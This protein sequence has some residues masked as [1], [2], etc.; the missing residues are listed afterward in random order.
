M[1]LT[2]ELDN[3]SL[4]SKSLILEVHTEDSGNLH[5]MYRN[6]NV[7]KKEFRRPLYFFVSRTCFLVFV[8][9]PLR[10]EKMCGYGFFPYARSGRRKGGCN[11]LCKP[12]RITQQLVA[13]IIHKE[14]RH[15]VEIY[16]R[17]LFPALHV[18]KSSQTADYGF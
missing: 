4:S 13:R 10:L 8:S 18:R 3:R 16:P 1:Y 17:D 6:E 5:Q 11:Y 12:N 2:E 14:G 7:P 15:I 9:L